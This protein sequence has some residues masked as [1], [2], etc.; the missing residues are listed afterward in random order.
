MEEQDEMEEREWKRKYHEHLDRKYLELLNYNLNTPMS[1]I[2]LLSL[3]ASK[4]VLGEREFFIVS[5]PNHTENP[6]V[7]Y[8]DENGGYYKW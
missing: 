8:L 5:L 3:G 7:F 4:V 2:E 6:F 1:K